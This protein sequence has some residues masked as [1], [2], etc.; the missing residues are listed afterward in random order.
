MSTLKLCH[1]FPMRR[2]WKG[3]S[4]NTAWKCNL[5]I[6]FKPFFIAL[7]NWMN[8]YST[9]TVQTVYFFHFSL[10]VL[11]LMSFLSFEFDFFFFFF[12]VSCLFCESISLLLGFITAEIVAFSYLSVVTY[13][14][15]KTQA[16]YIS[17]PNL[18]LNG[19][20]AILKFN[21][22]LD[23]GF[24]EEKLFFTGIRWSVILGRT[25]WTWRKGEMNNHK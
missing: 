8:M 3:L 23:H 13:I 7:K 18:E 14:T 16:P 1:D 6:I 2:C 12:E 22:F 15:M 5:H 19:T 24:A 25:L 17:L 11:V 21:S 4:W 10:Q 20:K 9:H